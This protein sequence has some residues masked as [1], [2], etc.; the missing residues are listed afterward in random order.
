MKPTQSAN[1]HYAKKM[2]LRRAIHLAKK[3]IYKGNKSAIGV[4]V[5][6][7]NY[8]KHRRTT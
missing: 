8:L 7:Y 5:L 6:L 4:S 2:A 3:E 1:K